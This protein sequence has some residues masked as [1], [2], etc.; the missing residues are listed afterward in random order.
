MYTILIK[1]RQWVQS[2]KAHVGKD[3]TPKALVDAIVKKKV[4]KANDLK[5]KIKTEFKLI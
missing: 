1:V 5:D 4:E 3:A 2:W